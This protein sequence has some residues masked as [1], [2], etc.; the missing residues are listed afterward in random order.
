MRKALTLLMGTAL[1]LGLTSSAFAL[2]VGDFIAKGD[3][4]TALGF[5][6]S[7]LQ[8]AGA[9]KNL[10]VT[11]TEEATWTCT[12]VVELGNGGTN[13]IEQQRASVETTFATAAARV[14]NQITG[15]FV[16][17]ASTSVSGPALESCPATPSGF[18]YDNNIEFES[19]GTTYSFE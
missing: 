8:A 15:W 9:N 16:T 2:E 17:D 6:N 18:V 11:T 4:Q 19:T 14:K 12:K 3:V 13:E 7:Q 10:V 5:N 1:A